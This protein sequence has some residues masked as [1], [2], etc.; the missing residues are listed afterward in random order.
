MSPNVK[1]A[2]GTSLMIQREVHAALPGMD[3]YRRYGVGGVGEWKILKP[4]EFFGGVTIS[5]L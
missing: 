1:L 2:S 5:L 3:H 4:H